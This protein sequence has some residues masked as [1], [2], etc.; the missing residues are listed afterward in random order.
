MGRR[1]NSFKASQHSSLM[2]ISTLVILSAVES[3]RPADFV[4]D[5]AF[6]RNRPIRHPLAPTDYP[7]LETLFPDYVRHDPALFSMVNRKLFRNHKGQR[8]FNPINNKHRAIADDFFCTQ[9]SMFLIHQTS[10][11]TAF[12]TVN[13][14]D[15]SFADASCNHDSG[16]F[17]WFAVG[18]DASL[19]WAD[20]EDFTTNIGEGSGSSS[21]VSANCA[22][23]NTCGGIEYIAAIFP[24]DSCG[25]TAEMGVND[26]GDDVVVFKNKIRN[27]AYSS[28]MGGQATHG[29]IATDAVVDFNVQCSYLATYESNS[30]EM[31]AEQAALADNVNKDAGD[32]LKV[33]VEFLNKLTR[34]HSQ[35]KG[36]FNP[37]GNNGGPLAVNTITDGE[38][39]TFEAADEDNHNVQV[40]ETAYARVYLEKPNDQIMI[41]VDKCS[42]INYDEQELRPNNSTL[43]YDFITANC[44]DPFTSA[45]VISE[46]DGAKGQT[47]ISFTMFEF[48]DDSL[49]LHKVQNNYL[50]CKVSICIRGKTCPG[51]CTTTAD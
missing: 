30:L 25:T 32:M 15:F 13:H 23:D 22:D 47:L 39:N 8:G 18:A 3:G 5:P 24:L 2:K 41:Q 40:G 37:L 31:E 4:L 9:D 50:E 51:A 16:N 35:T 45:K 20:S 10:N 11:Y 19:D 46:P 26:D 21:I 34:S 48:V 38:G 17:A 43:S 42:L 7:G 33:K 6:N 14:T 44:G 27:G 1:F 49:K 28:T 12:N 36:G 29:G